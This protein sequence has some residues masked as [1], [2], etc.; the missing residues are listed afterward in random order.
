MLCTLL[1]MLRNGFE[2]MPGVRKVDVFLF[3]VW[4]EKLLLVMIK[5]VWH[6]SQI[7]L[8]GLRKY[9]LAGGLA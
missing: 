9:R 5:I 7:G 6:H 3:F 4:Q 8:Q 1:N 2:C